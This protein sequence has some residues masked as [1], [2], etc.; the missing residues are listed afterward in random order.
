MPLAILAPVAGLFPTKYNTAYRLPVPVMACPGSLFWPFIWTPW[1]PDTPLAEL[2]M[3][4]NHGTLATLATVANQVEAQLLVNTLND[5]GIAGVATGG[6][7]LQFGYEAFGVVRVLVK[8]ESLS[9]GKSV[10]AEHEQERCSSEPANENS[11]PL[12]YEPRL[13]RF[14]VRCLAI[15]GLIGIVG[16]LAAWGMGLGEEMPGGL[17]PLVVSVLLVAAILTRRWSLRA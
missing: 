3:V 1:P 8:Q 10:L 4:S 17:V 14:A 5:H 13:T 6:F 7:T 15:M 12:G 9:A 2:T 16:I 11:E